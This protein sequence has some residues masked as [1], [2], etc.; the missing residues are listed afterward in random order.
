MSLPV[1][2]TN[3]TGWTVA[4]GELAWIG[5][6]N[7]FGLS[8]SDGGYFLDMSG[9]HDSTPWGGVTQTILT[10]SGETYRLSLDLGTDTRYDLSGPVSILVT[11][12]S[13]STNFTSTLLGL[14]QWQTFTFDFTASSAN[15]VITI[16]GTEDSKYIGLDNLSI[17]PE[18]STLALLGGG[19]LLFLRLRRRSLRR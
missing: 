18:P 10:T 13:S 1:G 9:Y 8:A 4:N 7:P 6:S 14:N 19:G 5:P 11:A 12:G 15:T 16:V 2:A 3:M 17:V